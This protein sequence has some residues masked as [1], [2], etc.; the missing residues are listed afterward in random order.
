[1]KYSLKLTTLLLAILF[2]S[3]I[4]AISFAQ[5]E[6]SW[7]KA[8]EEIEEAATA[9][10]AAS[11]KTLQ[12]AKEK[13]SEALS[14]VKGKSSEAW[15]VTKEKTV[16]VV[17]KTKEATAEA[18]MVGAEKSKEAWEKT[19]GKSVEVLEKTREKIHEMTAPAPQD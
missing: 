3:L 2:F 9:V 5:E 7:K 14:E 18:G 15:Q 16:E 4:A 12:E 11:K 1:M 6:G 19:K 17:E 8:G 10:G 13:S